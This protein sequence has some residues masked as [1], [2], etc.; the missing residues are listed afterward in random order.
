MTLWTA[1]VAASGERKTPALNVSVR[2]LDSIERANAPNN[3]ERR[4]AHETSVQ[5][6]REAL[7][8]WKTDRK[9]ALRDSREPP[10]M[11]ADAV[12]PG[13]FIEPRLFVSDTTVERMAN[14]LKVRPRGMMLIRDELSGF[15]AN[16]YR[17]GVPSRPFWLESWVG[18]RYV[19]ERQ[20]GKGS[21][22]VDHLLV[23][24]VGGFQPDKLAR[25][26]AGDDDGMSAR[27]L[28]GWPEKVN[29]KP[30]SNLI[31]EVDMTLANALTAL[32]RLPAE[33]ADGMF[34]SQDIGIS[35]DALV[36]FE[37]FRRW[38]D[39]EKHGFDGLEKTWLNKGET[40][41]LRLAGT[42]AYMSWALALGSSSSGFASITGAL[43]PKTIDVKF[44]TA[45]VELWRSFFWPHARAA[46]RQVGLTDR[47]RHARVVLN[48]IK[49]KGR[50]EVSREDIR[51]DAL[52]QRLDA[53]QT[54]KVLDDL[55]RLGWLRPLT[56]QTTG[57]PRHRWEINP[58]VF[59]HQ[60]TGE[61]A[62]SA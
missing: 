46:L 17:Y 13:N 32:I 1:L 2:A 40:M 16:M 30:L 62:R 26:F 52:G 27:F 28:Y 58:K 31:D 22:E 50:R 6:A 23:G 47:H 9:A 56:T 43:E 57:R 49:A 54:Q 24:V 59:L 11:P 61:T 34:A 41:V 51:R 53:E 8:T 25:A 38:L 36:E 55:T 37:K 19:V 4:F 7:K 15:F 29:Y 60:S 35:S 20:E 48:W 14:L 33:D 3:R 39:Q 45:A 10:P 42:L 5:R 44:M 21:V 12:D 18:G